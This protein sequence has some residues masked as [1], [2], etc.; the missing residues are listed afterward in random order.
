[1][2]TTA[3]DLLHAIKRIAD[4][5]IGTGGYNTGRLEIERLID[6]H[7]AVAKATRRLCDAE[8]RLTQAIDNAQRL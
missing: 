2:T 5:F 6:A 8:T 4:T 3:S 7:R 1:M